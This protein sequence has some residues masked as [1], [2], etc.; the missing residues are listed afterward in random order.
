MPFFYGALRKKEYLLPHLIDRIVHELK[1]L[2]EN[3][4]MINKR[5][6]R[7]MR[8]RFQLCIERGG[9]HIERGGR[10]GV[11]GTVKD[12]NKD[13]IYWNISEYPALGFYKYLL[14]N[15]S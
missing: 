15:N 13:F 14:D 4:E 3:P 12:I 7:N 2:K 11:E 10:K 8:R 5:A 9:G 6:V 1:N